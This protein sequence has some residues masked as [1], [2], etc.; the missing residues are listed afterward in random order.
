[1]KEL[2]DAPLR[3]LASVRQRR[4]PGDKLTA[5]SGWVDDC[6]RRAEDSDLDLDDGIS[7]LHRDRR[8]STAG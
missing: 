7:D 2:A 5:G 1:L 8:A 3:A 4:L 6:E